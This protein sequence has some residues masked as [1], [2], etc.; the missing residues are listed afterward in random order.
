MAQLIADEKEEKSHEKLTRDDSLQ[1]SECES[2]YS[3]DSEMF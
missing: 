1:I 3:Q 2:K